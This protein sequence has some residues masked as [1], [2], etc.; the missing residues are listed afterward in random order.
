L[1]A[2]YDELQRIV[3]ELSSVAIPVAPERAA[4]L[5]AELRRN[6]KLVLSGVETLRGLVTKGD[7]VTKALISERTQEVDRMQNN[8]LKLPDDIRG[9]KR[10]IDPKH[11]EAVREQETSGAFNP[12]VYIKGLKDFDLTDTAEVTEFREEWER[13]RRRQDER[14]EALKEELENVQ[15]IA[16][17]MSTTLGHQTTVMEML[18]ERV[19]NASGA[20]E[21]QNKR[22]KGA[23]ERVASPIKCCVYSFLIL[24]LLATGGYAYYHFAGGYDALFGQRNSTS[25]TP[26]PTSRPPIA[27]V[28]PSLSASATNCTGLN[29]TALQDCL[30]NSPPAAAPPPLA[31]AAQTQGVAAAAENPATPGAMDIPT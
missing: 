12:P 21:S 17:R 22:L 1:K 18:E 2:Q 27:A 28:I 20:L 26:T 3:E 4:K 30:G 13:A 10:E 29:G 19:D 31:T 11:L 14:L 15:D 25:E 7:R 24:A 5:N 23:I 9:Q 8:A 16:T 6:K